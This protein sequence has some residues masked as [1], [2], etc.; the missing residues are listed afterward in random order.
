[1]Q[2]LRCYTG[3]M[4]IP[5]NSPTQLSDAEL[6]A[7]MQRLALCERA[8]TTELLRSLMEFD[9]RRLYLGEGYPSL[10]AYCTQVLHY[11]EHAALNRIEVARAARRI[12]ILLD[13]VA[14]GSLNITGARLL[15][16][17]LNKENAAVLLAAARHKSKRDIEEMVA[18]LRPAPAVAPAIRRVPSLK[19]PS[20]PEPVPV[21]VNET[22]P[23]AVRLSTPAPAAASAPA[24]PVIAPLSAERFQVR[25]TVTHETRDKLRRVQDLMRHTIPDGDI[26]AV[27]DRAL[28]RLLQDLQRKRFAATSQPRD[29]VP[30]NAGSRH[31]PAGVRRAVWQRDGGRCAFVGSR[32]RCAEHGFLEFHHVMPF[33]AGGAA[34]V[35]NIELR[36][37]AHNAY[38][39][40]LFF[41][42][43]KVDVVRLL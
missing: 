43:K 24:R 41:A 23:P 36:C 30:G 42:A 13:H 37:R 35:E 15:A 9:A 19:Q 11:A 17:H 20:V 7:D 16:P 26:A 8:A 29:A 2:K 3:S 34:T 21:R 25:F 10:F 28:T 39:T 33:A 1:L 31:I 6:I 5:P 14:D 4:T 18:A 27:F 22:L 12:P 32:G 40:S 38:E